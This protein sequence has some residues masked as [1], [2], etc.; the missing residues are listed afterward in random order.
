V[1]LLARLADDIL[2]LYVCTAR[3]QDPR[4]GI[5]F[6]EVDATERRL[7]MQRG[8]QVHKMRHGLVTR[9]QCCFS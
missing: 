7:Q 2:A 1:T 4:Q 5:A 9:A 3:S 6:L 8:M